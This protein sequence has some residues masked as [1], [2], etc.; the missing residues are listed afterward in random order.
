ML[1]Y[2]NK[3]SKRGSAVAYALVMTAVVS[4]LLVSMISY[5]VMQLKFSF[6]RVEREKAFQVAEAGVYYYRWYLAHATDGMDAQQLKTFWQDSSTLG[7][8]GDYTAD[9][10]DSETGD[11]LGSYSV[12]LDP[13][14]ANSTIATITVTGESVKT[15]DVQRAVRVRFRRPSWS[16]YIFLSN[17]FMNF[18]DQAEVFGKVHSNNGIRFDGLAHNTVSSLLPSFDDP[19]HGGSD[20]SLGVHTHESAA[21]V[22]DDAPSYPWPDGTVPN[23]PDIFE[24][25]RQF[26][27]PEVS[28]AGISA[29]FINMKAEAEAGSGK[30]FNS[31]GVGRRIN[32]KTD[33][34]Y[35]IC[36]V[37]SANPNHSISNY[38][39]IITGASGSYSGTNGDA[40]TV[41]S[42]CAL[43]DCP[44][45]QGS[46]PA[47]GKCV[48]LNNYN[49]VD[50]GVIFV[51]DNVWFE[52]SLNN[53]RVTVAAADLSGGNADIYIGISDYD[54]RLADYNCDNMLGLVAQKDIL[55]LN[56]CPSDFTVDAALLAQTGKVGIVTGMGGKYALTFNGAIA[57][58]LQPYFKSGVSGFEG[59]VY[60]F[61]NQL[62][63]C[64]PPYFPTGTEYSIDQWEEL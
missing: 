61:N 53:R 22:E 33:G 59:R 24:G 14:G 36:T 21:A 8:T 46:K 31:D 27:V 11:K 26:P 34:T 52:G 7:V 45:I 18:G 64:P 54:I 17:S 3:N 48:S 43:A 37:N 19:T 63:Y 5:I 60:N 50:N 32:I 20:L 16:E 9:F 58:F 1:I 62:L 23:R 51:E 57:S 39:G 44:H 42:C 49:I 35:D 6:N 12:H 40:C 55:V 15:P 25:G 41:S 29:D 56:D 2:K 38:K 28:F 47:R 30:Y 4:I 13:P 10:N